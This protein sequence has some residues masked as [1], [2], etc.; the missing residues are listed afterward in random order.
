M[1]DATTILHARILIVDDQHANVLL[2]EQML[3]ARGYTNIA[4]TMDPRS[5]CALH[6]EQQ[7]DLILLD[8]QM[9]L[10][11]GFEVMD[12]LRQIDHS[13][14]LPVLVITAQPD[15]KLR[16]LQ[17]GARDFV[18]KPFDVIEVQTRIHNM[19]EVR[20]L[21]RRLENHKQLLEQAVAE[22]TEELRI[23]EARFKSFTELSSDWYWEQDKHGQF[24]SLSGTAVEILGL[25][26]GGAGWNTAE[27]AQLLQNIANRQPFLDFICHRT[28]PDGDIQ[29]MQVSGEP[30]FDQA[31]RFIGYRGVGMDITPRR[32]LSGFSAADFLAD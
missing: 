17:A 19:L 25:E 7:F 26:G 2:L 3:R 6:A 18:S 5:V 12:E 11:D 24:T 8:L 16:A 10:M 31:A 20:L 14:Y 23:S 29:T 13:S 21:Y 15:H 22:R 28:Q 30:V 9:P 1:L 32:V 27:H 4:S